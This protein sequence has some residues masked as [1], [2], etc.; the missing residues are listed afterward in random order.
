[1]LCYSSWRFCSAIWARINI[2]P[3]HCCGRWWMQ[4]IWGGKVGEGFTSINPWNHIHIWGRFNVRGR[5]AIIGILAGAAA[6]L[7]LKEAENEREA[8]HLYHAHGND[9]GCVRRED[10]SGRCNG[11]PG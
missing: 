8:N 5:S 3:R 11:D 6:R 1:M 4:D 10:P 2:V 9:P 7:I